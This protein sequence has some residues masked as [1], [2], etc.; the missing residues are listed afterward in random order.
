MP[1]RRALQEISGNSER[2]QELSQSLRYRIVGAVENGV[3][4][5]QVAR[6]YNVDPKTVRET[7]YLDPLH[8]NQ[9]SLP[10]SGM[11]RTW[12]RHLERKILCFIRKVPKASYPRI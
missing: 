7:V 1:R 5:R 11:P 3:P 8:F 9:E 10:R 2:R 12:S 6:F 4:K